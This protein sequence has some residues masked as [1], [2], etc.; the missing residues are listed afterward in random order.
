M[1]I[2]YI[3]HV[4]AFLHLRTS[5]SIS[6]PHLG[7]ILISHKKDKITNKK[8]QK[9]KKDGLKE[10]TKRTLAY[11]MT[12]ETRRQSITLSHLSQECL[13]QV[14][15]TFQCSAC[16]QMAHEKHCKYWF[17]G[18]QINFSELENLQTWNPQ[19]NE[20]QLHI[21]GVTVKKLLSFPVLLPDSH[22]C[23]VS[24]LCYQR[25]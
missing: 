7:A 24:P 15:Q 21:E 16:L 1:S 14:T 4:R 18:L 12:T 22:C 11:R 23:Q 19:N 25:F 10:T 8:R 17:G 2:F 5:H 3:R 20:N 13:S 9:C 6:A